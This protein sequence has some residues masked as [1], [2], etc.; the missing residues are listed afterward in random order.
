MNAET[1]YNQ[2]HNMG[3]NLLS[4]P[5][6][7]HRHASLEQPVPV[8]V[9]QPVLSLN[10]LAHALATGM[11]IGIPAG[12]LWGC[13]LESLWISSDNASISLL[14]YYSFWALLGASF[15]V[16]LFGT[17]SLKTELSAEQELSEVWLRADAERADRISRVSRSSHI[18]QLTSKEPSERWAA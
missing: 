15:G 6:P 18:N 1:G 14:S 9:R 17:R 12:L 13:F 10:S 2:V 3:H 7:Q 16:A 11:M 4:F 8:T 5:V